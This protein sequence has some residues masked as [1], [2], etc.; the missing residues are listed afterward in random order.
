MLCLVTYTHQKLLKNVG[1]LI[2]VSDEEYLNCLNMLSKK[3]P[4]SFFLYKELCNDYQ[5]GRGQ[6][7]S[8]ATMR[9]DNQ[10]IIPV[11]LIRKKS[12]RMSNS[13]LDGFVSHTSIYSALNANTYVPDWHLV[14][15]YPGSHRQAYR[16]MWSTQNPLFKQG[17]LEH[18]LMSVVK[19]TTRETEVNFSSQN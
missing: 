17:L 18:S 11:I 6:S 7:W 3:T 8:W 10:W 9:Q 1:Y 16:L 19:S 5:E 2:Y 13:L 15:V 14:P 12:S 4:S